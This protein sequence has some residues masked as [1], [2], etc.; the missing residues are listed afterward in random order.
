MGVASIHICINYNVI[1]RNHKFTFFYFSSFKD[2][3]FYDNNIPSSTKSNNSDHYGSDTEVE[4]TDN[5][6]KD[7]RE[8]V[9]DEELFETDA[10]PT[11]SIPKRVVRRKRISQQSEDSRGKPGPSYR[12][13]FISK[14]T[15]PIIE[16][17]NTQVLWDD[18]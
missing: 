1:Y 6:E 4:D 13:P 11:I 8:N 9:S 2:N 5:E 18:L 14:D 16:T 3:G 10:K 7:N 17:T 15:E 12:K